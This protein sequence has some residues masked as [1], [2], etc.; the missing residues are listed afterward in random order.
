[1]FTSCVSV[2]PQALLWAKETCFMR[3]KDWS[4]A[5]FMHSTTCSRSGCLPRRQPMTS[6]NGTGLYSLDNVSVFVQLQMA[7]ALHKPTGTFKWR[8]TFKEPGPLVAS[9]TPDRFRLIY[10]VICK[11]FGCVFVVCG[12]Y[13]GSTVF[14]DCLD[15]TW[16]ALETLSL[17]ITQWMDYKTNWIWN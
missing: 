3:S 17:L 7:T 2:L 9:L 8:M 6:A 5:R 10:Y 4:C 13:V 1:M 11:H 16:S 15:P 14:S 12:F